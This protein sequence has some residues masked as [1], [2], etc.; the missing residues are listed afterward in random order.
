MYLSLGKLKVLKAD[1]NGVR[2]SEESRALA[3]KDK[4]SPAREIIAFKQAF[5][6][7]ALRGRPIH[8]QPPTNYI[9]KPRFLSHLYISR[10]PSPTPPLPP[11]KHLTMRLTLLAFG[12]TA[13]VLSVAALKETIATMD[14]VYLTVHFATLGHMFIVVT[15]TRHLDPNIL[16]IT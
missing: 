9:V 15:A 16:T 1:A 2:H 3:Y 14:G 5:Y 4:R 7:R 6:L 8:L 10:P 12:I 13:Q 11:T